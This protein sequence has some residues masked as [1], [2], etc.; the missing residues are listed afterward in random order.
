[1]MKHTKTHEPAPEAQSAAPGW[2][3]ANSEQAWMAVAQTMSAVAPV[4][5]SML[6]PAGLG[7]DAEDIAQ[8]A[9]ISAVGCAHRWDPARGPLVS[10]VTSIGKRRAI[11]HLRRSKRT[12]TTAVVF[13]GQGQEDETVAVIDVAEA[14]FEDRLLDRD[15]AWG[16]VQAVL[17]QVQVVLRNDETMHR[18]LVVL[19]ECDGEIAEASGKLGVSAPVAR[20]ARREVVRMAIVVYQ[21]QQLHRQRVTTVSV[22]AAMACLPDEAG[23]WPRVVLDAIARHGSVASFGP[24]ELGAVTGWSPSTCRQRLEEV[25]WL[26]SVIQDIAMR[27]E[28]TAAPAKVPASLKAA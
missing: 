3:E 21:A 8:E 20:E 2:M 16:L 1:M 27:G 11:D 19:A 4:I 25:S 17:G 7:A 13:V 28:I 6:A 22:E 15:E 10:W 26:L 5:R 24:G 12:A 18:A 9:I 14:S 23:S